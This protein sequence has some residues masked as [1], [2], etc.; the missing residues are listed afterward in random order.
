MM[1]KI[2]TKMGDKGKTRLFT[3]EEVPKNSPYLQAYGSV[4]ELN[5]ILGVATT[6][7]YDSELNSLLSLLQHKLFQLG[8]DLATPLNSKKA[9]RRIE[10]KDVRELEKLIDKYEE[11]L[12]PLRNFILPGGSPASAYLQLARTVC[13]RGERE[14]TDLYNQGKMNPSVFKYLNRFSDLLFVLA[15]VVNERKGT[16]E[17][18]WKL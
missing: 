14:S 7:L 2:Y 13:R 6:F 1:A 15:R 12:K 17:I 18:I 8:S 11:E 9:I 4:D 16:S 10:E 5:S 3:G